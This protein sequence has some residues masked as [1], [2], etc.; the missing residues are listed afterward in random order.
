MSYC[1]GTRFCRS[2]G[3]VA[4]SAILLLLLDSVDR[5]VRREAHFHIAFRLD[6]RQGLEQ[7]N[8]ARVLELSG[9]AAPDLQRVDRQRLRVLV[10]ADLLPQVL[11]VEQLLQE[12]GP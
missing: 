12:V 6:V 8:E 9:G 2:L 5:L 4:G 1:W 7:G 11:P 10:G 3:S